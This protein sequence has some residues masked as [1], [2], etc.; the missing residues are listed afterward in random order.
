MIGFINMTNFFDGVQAMVSGVATIGYRSTAFLV[1]YVV[2]PNYIQS[3]TE[4]ELM[5][6]QSIVTFGCILGFSSLVYTFVEYRPS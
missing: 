6:L 5:L 1:H 2:M 4:S 3:V